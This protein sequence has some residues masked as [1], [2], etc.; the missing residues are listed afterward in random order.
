LDS[1]Q[2]GT[3]LSFVPG[4]LFNAGLELDLNAGISLTPYLHAVGK[5][6]DSTSRSGRSEFGPYQILNLK[7][8]KTLLRTDSCVT[9]LFA[10]LNNLTN[11]RYMMPWQ[12]RDPGFNVLGGLDFRF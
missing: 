10:D 2:D 7:I 9:L 12:F 1:D 6:Y 8:E 5:Y 11:R 4:Y 3:A